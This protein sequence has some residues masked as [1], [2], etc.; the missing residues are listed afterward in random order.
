M[1]SRQTST[2]GRAAY[3]GAGWTPR[4]QSLGEELGSVWG[5]CGIDTEWRPL[6]SV[7]LH[8]PGPEL[9]AS[10]EPDA[11]L[12][13]AP[14]DVTKAAEEHDAMAEA[15][16]DA[17]VQVSYV[18]PAFDPRPNQMFC[19]DLMFSTPDGVILARPASTV[20]AGE[21]RELARRLSDL[22]VPIVRSV[23]GR[24]T[25][26]GADAAW[27]D[28]ATVVI[29][30]GHR[31]ND[32]GIEQVS[33][34]LARIDV[35]SFAVDLPFGTMHLMGMLRIVDFDLAVAWP[36]RIPYT[37]VVA[38]RERGFDVIFLP[39]GDEHEM[40]RA[41]NLVTLGPRRVLMN[42]GAD[43]Y[44]D[45]LE[46]HGIECTTIDATELVKAAGGFGCLTGVVWRERS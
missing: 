33:E 16:R 40:S 34:T 13:L 31:T 32:A 20:R 28:P 25:F 37:L 38:L 21:E 27:L 41:L 4:L 35:D 44:Q 3:G 7:V 18:D 8:R 30:R 22:G 11:V 17:G 46:S 26:E 45:F 36:R 12:M 6:R 42:G 24:G 2:F 10:R 1:M 15:Y 23:S 39:E 14:V 43:R 5:S 29:G 9:E 19:A